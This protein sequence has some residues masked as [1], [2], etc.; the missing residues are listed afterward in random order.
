MS[1]ESTTSSAKVDEKKEYSETSYS[2]IDASELNIYPFYSSD[3]S[4]ENK[5]PYIKKRFK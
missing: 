3:S 5:N 4:S 2:Q 1:E